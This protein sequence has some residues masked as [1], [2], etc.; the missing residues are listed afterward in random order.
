[1]FLCILRIMGQVKLSKRDFNGAN[2]RLDD[3]FSLKFD[4]TEF[5]MKKPKYYSSMLKN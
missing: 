4:S 3:P 5:Y 1:M 2:H